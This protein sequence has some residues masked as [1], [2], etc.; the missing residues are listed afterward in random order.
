M[1]VT[2]GSFLLLAGAGLI[3]PAFSQRALILKSLVLQ[4]AFGK[5]SIGA[6]QISRRTCP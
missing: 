2:W 5:V 3:S 4:A 6:E 1:R